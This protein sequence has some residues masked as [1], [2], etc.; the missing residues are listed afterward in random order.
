MVSAIL[1]AAVLL[2][3]TIG[4]RGGSAPGVSSASGVPVAPVVAGD[5]VL[6]LRT[7][8]GDALGFARTRVTVPAETGVTVYLENRSIHPHSW[9]VLAD[10]AQV[11]PVG[12]AAAE[13]E[14]TGFVPVD[15]PGVLAFVPLVAPMTRGGYRFVAPPPGRY[16]VICTF[17]DH[18]GTVRTTLVSV[19]AGRP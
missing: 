17:E 8:S 16:P 5:T 14:R 9:V 13:A 3:T 6:A 18:A 15:H 11:G 7:R 10:S 4:A 2:P 1:L 19:R 12:E